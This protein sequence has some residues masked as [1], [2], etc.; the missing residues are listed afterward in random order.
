MTDE[1]TMI[2]MAIAVSQS[3]RALHDRIDRVEQQIRDMQHPP[4]DLLS[5]Q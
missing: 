1:D 2:Q 4:E 5:Y 3:I